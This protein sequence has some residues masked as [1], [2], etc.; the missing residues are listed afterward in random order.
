MWGSHT[1][2]NK[3]YHLL[4]SFTMLLVQVYRYSAG[5]YFFHLQGRRV[6]R[7]SRVCLTPCLRT[8]SSDI[9]EASRT[10]LR[11]GVTLRIQQSSLRFGI[12]SPGNDI[13]NHMC[14][15]CSLFFSFLLEVSLPKYK[16]SVTLVL[17]SR[18]A[19]SLCNVLIFLASISY[20]RARK[21]TGL[22]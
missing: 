7:T 21:C 4:G 13:R 3:E 15:I 18:N 8:L 22:P 12:L 11:K 5:S 9:T 2:G 6:S 20:Q 10:F 16:L 1:S 19:S 17:R 14:S